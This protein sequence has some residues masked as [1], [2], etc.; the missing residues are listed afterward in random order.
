MNRW[1]ARI[2]TA[3]LCVGA[4]IAGCDYLERHKSETPK[5]NTPTEETRPQGIPEKAPSPQPQKAPRIEKPKPK[6]K[7]QRKRPGRTVVVEAN[8]R[9]NI[10]EH[11][12]SPNYEA[13]NGQ[14]ESIILHTTEG[15]GQS[16]I[17]TFTN[18]KSEV[19][20]H[21][22]VMENGTIQNFVDD[23]NAA[24]H[25]RGHN[26]RSIGIEFAG[27]YNQPLDEKQ[28]KSGQ[29]LIRYLCGQYGLSKEDLYPHSELDPGRRTDPGEANLS[30][31]LSGIN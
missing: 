12:A 16:A 14:I 26:N 9:P 11:W 13:R 24:W 15:T 28:I 31:I 22:L 18:E 6:K 23:S 7:R 8:E 17:N 5:N 20:A 2:V 21:Y 30:A 10:L 4:G 27:K 29:A 25:C 19:S 1:Y 3:A